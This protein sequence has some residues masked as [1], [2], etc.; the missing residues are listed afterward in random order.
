[1]PK[2]GIEMTVIL[3]VV[4]IVLVLAIIG[5]I[6]VCAMKKRQLKQ[7]IKL[8]AMAGEKDQIGQTDQP[9][10]DHVLDT[11]DAKPQYN[12]R[13]DVSLRIDQMA[14]RGSQRNSM[15][16]EAENEKNN[17]SVLVGGSMM[18]NSVV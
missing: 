8:K 6:F 1:M 17:N 14:S 9:F 13:Q 15:C 12:P 11:D 5:L 2:M 16:I 7:P 10:E 4:L 3:V 18:R